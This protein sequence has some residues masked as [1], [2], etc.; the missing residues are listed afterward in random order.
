M[1]EK[2]LNIYS[3]RKISSDRIT[4]IAAKAKEY[5]KNNGIENTIDGTI[6]MFYDEDES[7][8]VFKTIEEIIENVKYKDIFSYSPMNANKDFFYG[9][10]NLTGLYKVKNFENLFSCSPTSGGLG[11]IHHAVHN[12]CDNETLILALYPFWGPYQNIMEEIGL[13][14]NYIKPFEIGEKEINFKQI[15]SDLE[16]KLKNGE[17]K[18]IFFLLNTPASNPTGLSLSKEE[19]LTLYKIFYEIKENFNK[20]L[21]IILFLDLAYIDFTDFEVLDLISV[22]TEDKV[23]NP[24]DTILM[25]FSLSKTCGLYGLRAGS[26]ILFSKKLEDHKIF[27]EKFSFSSRASTGSINHLGY[28]IIEKFSNILYVKKLKEEQKILREKLNKRKNILLKTLDQLNYPYYRHDDG[29]FITYKKSKDQNKDEIE[30]YYKELENRGVFFVPSQEGLRIAICS[31]P[32]EKIR[33]L[34]NY[35]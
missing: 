26:A 34:D 15:K 8:Y 24:F 5:K 32:L 4:V 23:I 1:L 29:F 25:G 13:K 30:K 18:K 22:F 2:T 9:I 20:D 17:F 31:I 10:M 35:L 3:N 16:D 28:Y 19:L 14:M 7:I 6:G 27:E 33:K 21:K 12:F 11:A